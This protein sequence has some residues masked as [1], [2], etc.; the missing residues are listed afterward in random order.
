MLYIWTGFL[1]Y[2]T[3]LELRAGSNINIRNHK[4]YTMLY[5]RHRN[6]IIVFI[7]AI[8]KKVIFY[9]KRSNQLIHIN[10]TKEVKI[11]KDG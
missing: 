9:E 8:H 4:T 5:I 3:S 1:V 7:Q 10:E 11:C 2:C 6:F